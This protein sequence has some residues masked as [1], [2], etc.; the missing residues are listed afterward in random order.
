MAPLSRSGIRGVGLA[1]VFVAEPLDD[2]RAA[3]LAALLAELIEFGFR[4]VV[5]DLSDCTFIGSTALAVLLDAKRRL[6]GFGGRLELRSTAESRATVPGGAHAGFA[7][8]PSVPVVSHPPW[9]R[10]RGSVRPRRA[11]GSASSGPGR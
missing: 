8:A 4:R 11:G 7:A 6:S 3:G 5:V 10:F 2:R 1:E 9:P